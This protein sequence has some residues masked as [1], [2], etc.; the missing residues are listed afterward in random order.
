MLSASEW[1][2][3]S[4]LLACPG[5]TGAT[6]P[7]GD[8]GLTGPTGPSGNPGAA[9]NNTAITPQPISSAKTLAYTGSNP[10]TTTY[11]GSFT[12]DSNVQGAAGDRWLLIANGFTDEGSNTDVDAYIVVLGEDPQNN[13]NAPGL[14]KDVRLTMRT[15]GGEKYWTLS[16]VITAAGAITFKCAIYSNLLTT[17]TGATFYCTSFNA[18]KL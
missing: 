7:K 12:N 16:G 2:S 18:I 6:G 3:S 14:G 8:I 5:P 9:T 4:K 15:D 13:D 1:T 11:I 10:L 17:A